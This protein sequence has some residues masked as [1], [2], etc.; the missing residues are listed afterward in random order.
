M[1]AAALG[2][3][4]EYIEDINAAKAGVHYKRMRVLV[5]GDS[6]RL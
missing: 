4:D 2:L 3:I 6:S 5:G 1:P